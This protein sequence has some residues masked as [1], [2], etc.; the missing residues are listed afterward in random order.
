MVQGTGRALR[1]PAKA[2][3]LE[4]ARSDKLRMLLLRYA[5]ALLSQVFQTAACNGHHPV[6]KRL[7]RWLMEAHD[8]IGGE[9]RLSHELLAFMLGC[10]RSGVTVALGSLRS[11]GLIDASRGQIRVTDQKG[12]EAASCECYRTVQTEYRRLLP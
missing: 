5:Q 12:L 6:H 2:F 3:L 4:M 11:K 9:M 10:R 7:A 1:I 8:R